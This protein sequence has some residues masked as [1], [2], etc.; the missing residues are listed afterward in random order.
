MQQ[1]IDAISLHKSN[2]VK[3]Q[4]SDDKWQYIFLA[5]DQDLDWL[6]SIM[7]SQTV[8]M[9]TPPG[10]WVGVESDISWNKICFF[11][12]ICGFDNWAVGEE[13]VVFRGEDP[14]RTRKG[15]GYMD[16]WIYGYIY[17]KVWKLLY[18]HTLALLWT[19][20]GDIRW[21][22]MITDNKK[23]QQMTT[24]DIRWHQITSDDI[25][26]HQMTTNDIRW[27]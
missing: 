25:R 19:F 7:L 17:Q 18:Q 4:R 21:Q 11:V 24:D 27:H 15:H 13:G 2:I 12:H 26:W 5:R 14:S 23:W 3:I 20:Q 22:Q 9:M 8:K 1:N 16:I 6:F 10:I